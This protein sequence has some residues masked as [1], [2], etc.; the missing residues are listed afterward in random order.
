M[1]MAVIIMN[2][3]RFVL[4]EGEKTIEARFPWPELT[5]E[6]HAKTKGWIW[7][8]QL[9]EG[10]PPHRF[11]FQ[12]DVFDPGNTS[13]WVRDSDALEFIIENYQIRPIKRV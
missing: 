4:P 8:D 13:G 12:F 11:L 1:A 3:Y 10:I 7:F 9:S 5:L 2:F 6:D